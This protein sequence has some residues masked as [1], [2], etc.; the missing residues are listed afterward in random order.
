[1][2]LV[3]AIRRR[4]RRATAIRAALYRSDPYTAALDLTRQR[5][6]R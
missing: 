6:G 1:M 3:E 4:R 2:R 5:A